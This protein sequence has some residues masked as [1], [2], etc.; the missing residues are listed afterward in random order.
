MSV[1]QIR[2]VRRLRT[3]VATTAF[4]LLLAAGCAP[5][6][7]PALPD[8]PQPAPPGALSASIDVATAAPGASIDVHG[9]GYPAGAV[10]QIGIGQP[11]S[12]FSIV[13]T[14]TADADGRVHASVTVPNWAMRGHPY[15]VVLESVDPRERVITEPFVVGAPG[16]NISVIGTLT[17]EG[18]ECPAMRGR[19]GELYTL[20][21][22][23]VEFEVGTR[24]RVTGTIAEVAVCMQG[25]TIQV[26]TI[27]EG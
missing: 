18:V 25:T 1:D 24:V 16:D 14:A 9:A 19:G 12:E 17:D 8:S 6:D 23:D 22:Q 20:A 26:E 2:S 3:S 11:D 21:V 10:V 4:G 13:H 27:E 5:L 7:A 15:V